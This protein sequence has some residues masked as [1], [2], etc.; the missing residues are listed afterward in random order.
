[1]ITDTE[2]EVRERRLTALLEEAAGGGAPPDLAERVL[3]RVRSP[4]PPR[5]R[6]GATL[7]AA[8][9]MLGGIAVVIATARL[10]VTA[11]DV[12]AQDPAPAPA[13]VV[14]ITVNTSVVRDAVRPIDEVPP[15]G[16]GATRL[17]SLARRGPIGIVVAPGVR[18]ESK[19]ELAGL[20][21]HEAVGRIAAELG[22]GVADFGT[23]V[24]VGIGPPARAERLRC[25][26]NVKDLDVRDLG[27][28]LHAKAGMNLVVAGDLAGRVTLDV[29]AVPARALLDVVAQKLSL[30]VVG[31]GS[32]LALR[33]ASA[34]AK[35]P[36]LTMY[37]P[38]L[39]IGEVLDH[40]AHLGHA[41]MVIAPGIAGIVSVRA[42]SPDRGDLLN[43]LAA[44]VGAEVQHLERGVTRVLP[45]LTQT[46]VTLVAENLPEWPTFVEL[47]DVK[48]TIDAP[49]S[50]VRIWTDN[51]RAVDVLRAAAVATGRTFVRT[52]TGYTIK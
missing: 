14:E 36:G 40:F 11:G 50:A 39:A 5:S 19:G 34:R 17:L 42:N 37:A 3:S 9:L 2:R 35:P 31:C 26:V 33:R 12:P 16:D 27:K 20:T 45:R 25:S 4:R 28:V 21:W 8:L 23:M 18:G 32:V 24:V 43:A 46:D 52:D 1:V 47:G 6:R 38:N 41:N 51:A 13:K 29:D 15:G 22:A 10:R 7:L 48:V 44:A 30:D 49:P